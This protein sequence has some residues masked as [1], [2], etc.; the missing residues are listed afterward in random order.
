M[1]SPKITFVVW[2]QFKK[3]R[4]LLEGVQ[5]RAAEMRLDYLSYEERLSNL[6]VSAWRKEDLEGI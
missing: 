2:N 6:G 5:R 4:N 1:K 3:G